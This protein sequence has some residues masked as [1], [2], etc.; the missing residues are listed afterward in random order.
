MRLHSPLRLRAIELLLGIV[1][2]CCNAVEIDWIGL[3]W[4]ELN[5]WIDAFL[6]NLKG[7]IYY[8][9][10]LFRVFVWSLHSLFARSDFFADR[11]PQFHYPTRNSL[12]TMCPETENP[13]LSYLQNPT[14]LLFG[15]KNRRMTASLITH[16]LKFFLLPNLGSYRRLRTNFNAPQ[17]ENENA[18][19]V[20]RLKRW[21]CYLYTV[22]KKTKNCSDFYI[23]A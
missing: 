23:N 4:I 10:F 9:F 8:L 17:I 20:V 1:S 6:L 5:S 16:S 13:W 22:Y 7:G 11:G 3:D 19:A 14:C 21:A 15:E 18:F 2:F 12:F